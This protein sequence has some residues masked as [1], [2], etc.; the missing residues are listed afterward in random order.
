[1]EEKYPIKFSLGQ[2]ILLLGVEVVV[3]ALIFLLGARFGANIFPGMP[4]DQYAANRAYQGLAPENAP[5]A[6]RAKPVEKLTDVPEDEAQNGDAQDGEAAVAEGDNAED[7]A[8]EEPPARPSR[9]GVNK[10]L[11]NSPADKNTLIRFKSS[12]ATHFAIE[13]GKYFDELLASK[14]VSKLKNKGYE[15]YLTIDS[16]DG[17][18]TYGVRV[19]SFVERKIAEDYATKMS[20]EQGIELRVVQVD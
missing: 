12:N 4:A 17:G 3:L 18:H 20:N 9:V 6:P 14:E 2:F 1:M 7:Q 13:V 15:A 5:P 10:S 19:G 8:G 11:L 16:S